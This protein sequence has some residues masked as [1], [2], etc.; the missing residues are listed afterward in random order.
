MYPVYE[1][2][3]NNVLNLLKA[4]SETADMGLYFTYFLIFFTTDAFSKES[5][6]HEKS[7]FQTLTPVSMYFDH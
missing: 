6:N 1:F 2:P 7:L 3:L 5:I 4:K